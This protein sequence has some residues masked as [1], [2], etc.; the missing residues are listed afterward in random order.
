MSDNSLESTEPS[1]HHGLRTGLKVEDIRQSFFDN[2]FYAMNRRVLLPE[3]GS[4]ANL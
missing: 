1:A 2:L 4:R 3:P